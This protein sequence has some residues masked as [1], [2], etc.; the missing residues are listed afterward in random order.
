M[1]LRA[2][3]LAAHAQKS[4]APVYLVSGDE[5]LQLNEACDVL[6]A[7]ARKQGYAERQVFNV[8]TGFDWDGL[9]MA[10]NSMSLFAERRILELRLPNAKPGNEGSK[11]LVE[12]AQRPAQDTVLLVITGK[13]DSATQKSVW[14]GA[15]EA[16]GVALQVWPV[17]IAQLPAWIERRMRAKGLQP[18]PGA[19]SLLV[20]RVE[21]NLLAAAQEIEKLVLLYGAGALDENQV[22]AAVVDSARYDIYGLADAALDGDGA[23]VVRMIEGLRGEG[24]DPVLILWALVREIRALCMMAREQRDGVAVGQLLAKYKVWDKRKALVEKTLKRH[25]LARLRH[26]LRCAG[27]IDRVIK[28]RETGNSWD[29]LVELAVAMSGVALFERRGTINV[30]ARNSG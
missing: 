5:P 20:E 21:G 29:E 10:A 6:R 8:E 26:M 18:A 11:A 17:E 15:L 28:G 9:L 1:K 4:L 3:Q 2:D 24:E 7:A 13:L 19:V 23:R 14:C 30:M 22:A 25:T 12:Y 27:R 16:A